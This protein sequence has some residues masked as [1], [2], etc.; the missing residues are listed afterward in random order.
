MGD[1]SPFGWLLALGCAVILGTSKA[2]LPGLGLLAAPILASAFRAKVSMGIMLPLLVCGDVFA[3]F[4]YHR[5]ADWRM[6]W[7]LLP[8]AFSGVIVGSL[9]LNRITDGQLRVGIGV[10]VLIMVVLTVL[11]NRGIIRDERLPKGAATAAVTGL[12]AGITTMMAHAAGPVM[13]VYFLAMG[14][15]KD[16]FIGTGAWFFMLVNAFKVPFYVGQG[17]ITVDSLVLNAKIAIGIPLGIVLGIVIV[18]R[19]S[20]RVFIL[21]IQALTALAAVKLILG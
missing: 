9:I 7:R 21:C 17:L 19:L 18:R 10:I 13:Q 1:L 14:L 16:A 5:H 15:K 3:V 11:R 8:A 2:G 20:N 12:V 4:Y 6:L